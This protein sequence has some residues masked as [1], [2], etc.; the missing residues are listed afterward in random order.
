MQKKFL[1]L[2]TQNIKLTRP[3]EQISKENG[4]KVNRILLI[5]KPFGRYEFLYKLNFFSIAFYRCLY[6]SKDDGTQKVLFFT[7]NKHREIKHIRNTHRLFFCFS[8]NQ[9]VWRLERDAELQLIN[10]LSL[11]NYYSA[12]FYL[13][14]RQKWSKLIG[15]SK[16]TTRQFRTLKPDKHKWNRIVSE[17]REL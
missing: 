8:F 1:N 9:I 15:S 4:L 12:G 10:V 17:G 16:L 13:L 6:I 14:F 11:L 5:T 2:S 3:E 7:G